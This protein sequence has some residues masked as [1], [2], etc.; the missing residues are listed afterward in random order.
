MGEPDR[1][2]ENVCAVIRRTG[3]TPVLLFHR[4]GYPPHQGWQFPQGGIDPRKELVV[5]LKRELREEIGTDAVRVV[6]ISPNT[7][8]YDFPPDVTRFK[9]YRGQRQRWVLLELCVG[10]DAI[11][12]EHTPAEFDS[13]QWCSV[14][15]AL[16]RIVSF[17]KDVYRRALGDLGLLQG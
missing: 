15:Q 9:R 4:K 11:H 16:E 17:K 14:Q 3:D 12:F 13:Y 5:E 8:K 6:C 2:R 10:D 7:Y 1:Y